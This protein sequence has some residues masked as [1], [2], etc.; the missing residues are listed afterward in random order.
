MEAMEGAEWAGWDGAFEKKEKIQQS[1]PTG[2]CKGK[3][4]PNK[5]IIVQRPR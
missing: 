1:L 4:N 2:L 3:N 5:P